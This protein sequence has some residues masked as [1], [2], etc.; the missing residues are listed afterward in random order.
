MFDAFR[1]M[2]RL[3]L[4]DVIVSKQTIFIHFIAFF[5][6]VAGVFLLYAIPPKAPISAAL[7]VNGVIYVLGFLNY[8]LLIFIVS[9]MVKWQENYNTT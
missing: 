8:L 7:T 2:K 3:K 5:S 9:G 1:R 6:F 4:K